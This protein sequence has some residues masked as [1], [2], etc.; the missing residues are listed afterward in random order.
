MSY[1]DWR[2]DDGLKRKYSGIDIYFERPFDGK[3]EARFDYTFS[4]SRGNNE[5]Q[6]KSEFGQTNIS[7]T[8]DW[9]V[10]EMMRYSY[11]YLAN[12][13]RHQLKARGSYQITEEL[14]LGGSLRVTSGGPVSCLG[15][16]NPDGSIDEASGDADP[17]GYGASYHTCFGQ[18]A[19]P[20]SVRLGWNKTLDLGLTYNPNWAKGLSLGLQVRNVTNENEPLQVDVTS[21]PDAAYTISN[22]YMLPIG[23]QTPRTVV[24][25]ASY[26]W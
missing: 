8:Q 25:T 18:I 12:D 5:G 9:D 24:F 10:A 21:E 2:F 19:T 3:W 22:S 16:Y 6:V 26:D 14:L 20:G 23:R 4:K 13:R 15:L 1:Q 17:V 7:K 11:G